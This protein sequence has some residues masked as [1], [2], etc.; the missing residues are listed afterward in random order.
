MTRHGLVLITCCLLFVAAS[1]YTQTPASVVTVST[2]TQLQSAVKDWRSGQTIQV[3]PGDYRLTSTLF[4]PQGLVDQ[5]ITGTGDPSM[6]TLRGGGYGAGPAF[7]IWAGSSAGLTVANLTIRDMR[8]HGV[9]LNQ[10]ASRPVIRNVVMTDIGDQFLKVNPRGVDDGIVED[11]VFAYS[12]TAPDWYT[13]GVDIHNGARWTIRRNTFRNFRMSGELVG[14]ALLVWNASHGT[15]VD[16][17]VF[18]DNHRDISMG[19]DRA[20]PATSPVNSTTL[21]DHSGGVVRANVISRTPGTGGDVA[22]A[23]FDSPNT[24]VEL[25]TVR[26]NGSYP[27]AVECRWPR[28]VSVIVSDNANDGQVVNRDGST[29]TFARNG[30]IGRPAMPT[31][32][33]VRDEQ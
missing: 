20:K 10:G 19:L 30:S 23:V 6:V 29:C 15:T 7:A 27:N 32:L 21:P 5:T 18:I 22:I 4:V 11:S 8:E 16:G 28:T 13:N 9:I 12:S 31:R 1:G 25:N 17:N 3:Q 24:L 33:R 14:P 2:E 26:L